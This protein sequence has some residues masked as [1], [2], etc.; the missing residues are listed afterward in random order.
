MKS[1]V[2]M[3]SQFVI[4]KFKTSLPPGIIYHNLAHTQEVV[5]TTKRIAMFSSINNSNLEMLLI[6][7]WFHD[8]G[9][10]DDYDNHEGK[11][12]EQC[13]KFLQSNN[14]PLKKIEI[15][16]KIILSTKL[17]HK[18]SN[19]L[20][21]IMCD[22]DI[23]YIG[24]KEFYLRSRILREEWEKVLDQKFSEKEWIET[25]INFLIQN[26]FHTKHAKLLFDGQRKK[27]LSKLYEML[28][29][30]KITPPPRHKSP[31]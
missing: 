23:C 14:Y 5:N 12:A 24:K 19:L 1:I 28:K 7:A 4:D 3:V 15:I 30:Y 2:N 17:P 26:K 18:P 31:S 21:R 13:H 25:N 6:A 11:S 10:I 9:Y 27:N 8:I 22:A 16:S 29:N 20:E